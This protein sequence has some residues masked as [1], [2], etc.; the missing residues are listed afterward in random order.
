[1]HIFCGSTDAG[2]FD[3]LLTTDRERAVQLFAIHMTLA[4][5]QATR[6]TVREISTDPEIGAHPE[7]LNDILAQG[8][9]AFLTYDLDQGWMAYPVVARFD[10][11]SAGQEASR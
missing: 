3:L 10:A 9:E 6:M 11:L 2:S 7:G 1:M 5:V 8:L 4:K